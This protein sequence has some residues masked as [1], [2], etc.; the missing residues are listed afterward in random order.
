[1]PSSMFLSKKFIG[2]CVF[3][4]SDPELKS[5]FDQQRQITSAAGKDRVR[6]Y[7]TEPRGNTNCKL[8]T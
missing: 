8:W 6:S 2:H 1:M 5:I 3:V 7:Q 4:G